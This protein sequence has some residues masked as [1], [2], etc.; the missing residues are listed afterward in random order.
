V[1][2]GEYSVRQFADIPDNE[3][4]NMKFIR[5]IRRGLPKCADN[6]SIG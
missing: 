3:S 2:D 4:R 1:T 6:I 5:R